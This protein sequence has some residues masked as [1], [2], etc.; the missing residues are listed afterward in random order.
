MVQSEKK[1]L[2]IDI[3]KC[4]K[5]ANISLLLLGII[6]FIIYS[7]LWG[8]SINLDYIFLTTSFVLYFV[9]I[10][11]HELLH[12]IGFIVFGKAVYK[13][14]KFGI[15]LRYF[16]PYAH[17]K[18]PMQNQNYKKALLLPV[19]VTGIIPLLIGITFEYGLL[20]FVSVGLVASGVGD[21]MIYQLIKNLPSETMIQDHPSEPGCIA[22]ENKS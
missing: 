12:A 4:T 18:I 21:M 10:I 11:A 7:L 19:I 8:I 13:D 22:L 5:I 9:L 14:I 2:L 6:T 20:T 3:K 16:M 17:C 15:I 1:E